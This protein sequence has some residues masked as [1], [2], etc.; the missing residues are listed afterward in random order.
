M[1]VIFL[2]PII[3][4]SIDFLKYSFQPGFSPVSVGTIVIWVYGYLFYNK[5]FFNNRITTSYYIITI[6]LLFSGALTVNPSNDLSRTFAFILGIVTSVGFGRF[7]I[8]DGYLSKM[9]LFFWAMNI[10]WVYYVLEL[11]LTGKI[12]AEYHF[13]SFSQ[14]V[15]TVNSHTV[16]IAISVSAV[17]LFNFHLSKATVKDYLLGFLM[18]GGSIFSMIIAQTRSNVTITLLM[19]SLILMLKFN[20]KV[21]IRQ[22]VFSALLFSLFVSYIPDIAALFGDDESSIA[23]RFDVSDE[24][25]QTSTTNSRKLVYIVFFERLTSEFF[26][27]GIIRPKL[28]LGTEDVTNLLMHNQYATWVVAGG[29][30]SLIGVILL[31]YS[32]FQ[33]FSYFFQKY[34]EL[35]FELVSLNLAILVYFITLFTVDQTGI[36]FMVF[37][38][39]LIYQQTI[40]FNKT[41]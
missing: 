36:F 28:F 18:L 22:I 8:K 2:A 7:L 41:K 25:Y 20:N 29:W 33:Y 21:N 34:K 10:Y 9:H 38:G 1:E 16:G 5:D 4:E 31:I 27:T 15:E 3:M 12:T 40:F 24:E 11:Y 30:I 19:A 13:N 26:G 14:D 17:Y 32:F 6:G 39:L 37:S 23:K 35:S